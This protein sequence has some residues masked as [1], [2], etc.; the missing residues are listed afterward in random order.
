[1][2]VLPLQAD[3]ASYKVQTG[4]SFWGIA[5]EYGVPLPLLQKS[6]NRTDSLLYPGE[7]L[8]VPDSTVS[9]AEKELLAKL[10]HA[11]AKGE[12][13]AGKV[14]VATVVLN[15]VDHQEFPDT[16]KDVIYERS[17][18]HYAFSPVENGAINETPDA[19]AEKAV[20]EALAFRGMGQGSIYFYNPETATSDWIRTREVTV[21][22]G[23]HVF[24]K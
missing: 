3:A 22:I 16:I 12:S 5:N 23:N 1:M 24:A 21:T 11:E 4:D 13:Y 10:V 6:N 14:A 20:N 8:V 15:R 7:T 2:L 18:G 17:G 19:E 9:Q